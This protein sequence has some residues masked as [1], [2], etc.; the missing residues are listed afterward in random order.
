MSLIAETQPVE[1]RGAAMGVAYTGLA[2]GVL[3]GPLIGGL[4]FEKLGRQRTFRLAA[5]IVLANALAQTALMVF[6]PAV[7]TI[8]D[9]TKEAEPSL[10]ASLRT[11]FSNREVL[12]VAAAIFCVNGVVGVIKPL[13]QV[14][15]DREFNMSIVNRSFV[16][17]IATFTYLLGTPI[18][19][20]LSDRMPKARLVSFSLLLMSLSTVFFSLR[21][22]GL[23]AFFICVGL[24]GLAM[25]FNGSVTQ[26]LLADLVDKHKLGKYSMAFALSDMADSLGLIIGPILGLAVSQ[27]LG[28]SVGAALMGSF[29]LALAPVIFRMA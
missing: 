17:T 13:S 20:Y 28:P 18:A 29:C 2:L 14:V 19:G 6:A 16:I 21:G 25:A 24:L 23:W 5:A 10:A 8:V 7:K 26:A 15:L 11:M 4:L 12:A 3:C 9:E 27:V 22:L 1:H